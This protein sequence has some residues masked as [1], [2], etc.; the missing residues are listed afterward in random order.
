MQ[1]EDQ[2][3]FKQVWR[4]WDVPAEDVEVSREKFLFELCAVYPIDRFKEDKDLEPEVL[5]IPRYSRLFLRH[6]PLFVFTSC[7]VLIVHAE[8]NTEVVGIS[9]MLAGVDTGLLLVLA[10]SGLVW[11]GILLGV[12]VRS[13]LMAR[14]MLSK[15]VFVYGLIGVLFAGNVYAVYRTFWLQA[16]HPH[17]AY[18]S[19]YLF[20]VLIVGLLGYD[21]VLKGE[22]FFCR[23]GETRLLES[24][25]ESD[26]GKS[27]EGESGPYESFRDNEL[28]E[29]L[30]KTA[31]KIGKI[32]FLYAHVFAFLVLLPFFGIWYVGKGPLGIDLFSSLAI[33]LI[34]DFVLLVGVFQFF[35]AATYLRKLLNGDI[36]Q[37]GTRLKFAYRPFHPDG[38]GGFRD[39]GKAA[40]HV[41]IIFILIGIYFVYRAYTAGFRTKPAGTQMV[42]G[43]V[44]ATNYLGPIL[45]Y[46][47][48]ALLWFYYTFWTIHKR[49]LK[50]KKETIANLQKSA[51]ACE[52][53]DRSTDGPEE[54]LNSEL[55]GGYEDKDPWQELND[56]GAPVWPVE[57]KKLGWLISADLLPVLL[58]IPTIIP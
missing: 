21:L 28:K 37:K 2:N 29:T 13:G 25:G 12:F 41:N 46:V 17:I 18:A 14:P 24:S 9:T 53:G 31:I 42:E 15:A 16:T 49:M 45:M 23:L 47:L 11:L 32:K 6:I 33:N 40:M 7:L 58:S 48:I 22:N 51:R 56:R 4:R 57:V 34:V 5:L 50:G 10:V 38:H 52:T 36:E 43:L 44:W 27:D 8:F 55:L 39:L 19:G 26:E 30:G 1:E 20:F 3:P 35:V 54:K